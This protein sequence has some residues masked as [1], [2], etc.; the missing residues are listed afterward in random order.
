MESTASAFSPNKLGDPSGTPGEEILVHNPAAHP[1][2]LQGRDTPRSPAPAL[3]SWFPEG[4]LPALDSCPH[5][6]PLSE[7]QAGAGGAAGPAGSCTR[8][9]PHG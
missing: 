9:E 5:S 3:H 2:G 4:L 8:G 7:R 1:Q 6:Q